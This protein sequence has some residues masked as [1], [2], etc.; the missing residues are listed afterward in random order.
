MVIVASTFPSIIE[1]KKRSEKQ[2]YARLQKLF[3]LMVVIS[4]GLALLATFLSTSIVILLF[5]EVYRDAG[6][7]LS[8]HIWAAVFVFLGVASSKWYLIEN[9]QRTMLIYG[10][11][12]ALLNI[13]L[14]FILITR[15]S[16]YGAALGTLLT[17]FFVNF[18]IDLINVKT[19]KIFLLK[20]RALNIIGIYL[21]N[22]KTQ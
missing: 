2:Y 19:R 3:D 22:Y 5:G 20:L 8:I 4:V 17:A 11:F 16:F 7:I 9:L 21:R 12:G 18:L 14:N 13:F 6:I 10:I 1:S 15:F